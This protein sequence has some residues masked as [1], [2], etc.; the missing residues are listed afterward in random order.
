MRRGRFSVWLKR[1]KGW[2]V[3]K[4]LWEWILNVGSKATEDA[5]AR[6]CVCIAGFPACMCQKKSIVY[7]TEC[8][9]AAVQRGKQDLKHWN[10]YRE[11]RACQGQN[12]DG[13][14]VTDRT[15]LWD[16]RLWFVGTVLWL[17]P[18]LPTETL[19]WLSSLPIW[20]QKSFR[21]WQCN[22]RYI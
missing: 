5:K 13:Y 20:M 6:S 22:D 17:C 2:T 14:L 21:W 12:R 19:K 18:S 3:S 15:D 16:K 7:K 9:H 8:R 11:G 10:A 4:V 1:W